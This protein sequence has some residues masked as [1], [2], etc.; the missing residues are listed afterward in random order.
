[1][2]NFIKKWGIIA[3]IPIIFSACAGKPMTLE[4]YVAKFVAKPDFSCDSVVIKSIGF[5][6]MTLEVRA[7][8]NNHYPVK[9]K[10]QKINFQ[11]TTDE[12]QIFSAAIDQPLDIS[13]EGSQDTSFD[14]TLKYA[15]II[16]VVREY[17]QQSEIESHFKGSVTLL[18][19]QV[20]EVPTLPQTMTVSFD[21]PHPIPTILPVLTIKKFSISKLSKSDIENAIKQSGK[22]LDILTMARVVE[23]LIAG[24]YDEAFQQIAPEDLKLNFNTV[25]TLEIKNKTKTQVNFN[26]INYQLALNDVQIIDG[27][28]TDNKTIDNTSLLTI[29][30][31]IN[32]SDF[33]DALIKA[34]MAKT[35][36]YHL[37]GEADIYF[38]DD[39]DTLQLTIDQAGSTKIE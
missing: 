1:M 4:E 13:K 11:L 12:G 3:L 23:A 5:D 19:P 18:L 33:T 29:T 10:L 20:P 8:I 30:S 25:L 24:N 14:I 15:D 32:S 22:S 26:N 7:S 34:I 35:A 31:Q 17:T 28:T 21:D 6:S 16:K 37:T 9:I 2:F 27:T 36:N 38:V 39:D